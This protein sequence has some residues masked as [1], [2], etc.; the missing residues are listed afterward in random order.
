MGC[1]ACWYIRFQC[2]QLIYHELFVMIIQQIPAK[3]DMREFFTFQ[4]QFLLLFSEHLKGISCQLPNLSIQKISIKAFL[5]KVNP[6]THT[7]YISYLWN[8]RWIITKIEFRWKCLSTPHI[9]WW[10]ENI[11]H[12]Q[13]DQHLIWAGP[14]WAA[15]S[16][17]WKEFHFG[18]SWVLYWRRREGE[19]LHTMMNRKRNIIMMMILS[20]A[21]YSQ[22]FF[23]RDIFVT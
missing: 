2:S 12:N 23:F 15:W 3:I 13:M 8:C 22:L 14:Y 16:R 5:T 1:T 6:L 20:N 11:E 17:C 10:H 7:H 21:R 4:K 18:K 9:P 19:S